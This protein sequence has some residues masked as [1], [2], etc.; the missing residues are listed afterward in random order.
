MHHLPILIL[1]ILILFFVLNMILNKEK[2]SNYL[3]PIKGLQKECAKVGL[4]PAYTPMSC[5]KSGSDYNPYS[6]CKCVDSTGMCKLCYPEIKKDNTES[7][8]VYN[9]DEYSPNQ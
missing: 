8:T 3:F 9:P 7:S 1:I 5:F 6:N 4:K 2:F